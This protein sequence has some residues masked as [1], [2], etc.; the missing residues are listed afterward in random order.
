MAK[1]SI[2]SKGRDVRAEWPGGAYVNLYFGG[3]SVPSEVINVYDHA[4][5]DVDP[6]VHTVVGLREIVRE[7]I[8][9]NDVDWPEWYDGYLANI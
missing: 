3:H 2:T 5:G 8:A 6:R 1:V 4:T 9:D 7:W